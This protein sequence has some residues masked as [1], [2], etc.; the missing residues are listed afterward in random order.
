M[1]QKFLKKPTQKWAG[2]VTQGVG[3]EFKPST[4]KKKKKGGL[5]MVVHVYNSSFLGGRSR[6]IMV[7]GQPKKKCEDPI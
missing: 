5:G 4:A 6:R 7:Q 2:G 3:P 1:V